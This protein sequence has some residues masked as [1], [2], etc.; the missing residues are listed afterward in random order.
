MNKII[1]VIIIF[2][3]SVSRLFSQQDSLEAGL[4]NNDSIHYDIT[5]LTPTASSYKKDPII[6]RYVTL[7]IT[8]ETKAHLLKKDSVFWISHLSN[9]Q[10]D[11]ATNLVLYF[12]YK[13]D[14]TILFYLFSD[15]KKWVKYKNTDIDYWKK[16]LSKNTSYSPSE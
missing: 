14:A 1:T 16:F 12:L 8:K 3:F 9:D 5:F 2:F 4:F 10:T 13:K 15:R 11:W 6:K 7:E